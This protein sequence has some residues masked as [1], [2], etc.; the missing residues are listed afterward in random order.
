MQTQRL[1]MKSLSWYNLTKATM[2]AKS[3]SVPIN[4]FTSLQVMGGLLEQVRSEEA[5][6]GMIMD[7]WGM[8]KI[9]NH[10]S[11]KFC[12]LMCTDSIHIQSHRAILL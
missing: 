11:V 8:V 1:G 4:S 10:C 12:V 6:G 9:L 3:F 5:Q 2:E 7:P